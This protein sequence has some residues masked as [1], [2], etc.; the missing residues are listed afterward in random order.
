MFDRVFEDSIKEACSYDSEAV[1]LA[2]TAQLIRHEL[3]QS[4]RSFE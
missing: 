3:F 2:K 1:Q 4:N